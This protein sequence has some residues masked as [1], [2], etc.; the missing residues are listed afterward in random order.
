MTILTNAE[1]YLNTLGVN[2]GF[3][4]EAWHPSVI[5]FLSDHGI[6]KWP[7]AETGY[8][9]W[10]GLTSDYPENPY[11]FVSDDKETWI[12][13]PTHASQASAPNAHQLDTQY[14][15][16][17]KDEVYD[18]F[19][20]DI[21]LVY[22][23]AN[24]QLV[25]Y[26]LREGTAF[27]GT[28]LARCTI[29]STFLKSATT[30]SIAGSVMNLLSP[31]IV[32]ESA[33][34][35]HMWTVDAQTPFQILYWSSADGIIWTGPT[36]CT[37]NAIQTAYGLRPWHISAKKN[38]FAQG[39]IDLFV[40][41]YVH[42]ITYGAYHGYPLVHAMTSLDDPTTIS[43]PLAPDFLLAPAH[44]LTWWQANGGGS[45]ASGEW[46]GWGLYRSASVL[47]GENNMV[48]ADVWYTGSDAQPRQVG[49]GDPMAKIGY[50]SG[51][52]YGY[53]S[54]A[55]GAETVTVTTWDGATIY[56]DFD[57][58]TPATE[59]TSG[60]SFVIP[61]G[62]ETLYFYA[63]DGTYTEDVQSFSVAVTQI[64]R[65]NGTTA[66]ILKKLNGSTSGTI[67][68]LINGSWN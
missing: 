8:R 25:A 49:T 50:T 14:N 38:P 36:T 22:D 47:R 15:D 67:K 1:T 64:K 52:L 3:G 42:P 66:G 68:R 61:E 13:A 31:S 17:D 4:F 10:G 62:A 11:L 16:E 19:A 57:D 21:E 33:S 54:A 2:N 63:T 18:S 20:A 35:W 34:S 56:A 44:D 9:Y 27:G 51:A 59:R 6:A 53:S 41:G 48:V 12:P 39:R 32:P 60:E 28:G 45:S 7:N 26:W 24:N 40:T 29:S 65:I 23:P 58:A 30:L 43:T 55:R 37:S 46:D 5:D